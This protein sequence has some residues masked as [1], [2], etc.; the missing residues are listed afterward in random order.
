MPKFMLIAGEAS[1]DTLGAELV[2][3]LRGTE[4]GRESEYF[5]A[6]GPKM[7]E[8]GVEL[9]I[10]MTKDSVI[11]VSDAIGKGFLFWR[12]MRF[13]KGLAIERKPDVVVLVDFSFFNHKFAKVLREASDANWRPKIVKYVS[14]QVWASRPGRANE[15]PRDFDLLLSIF[16]FEKAWYKE[17]IPNFR[18][19][20]VGHPM[21]DRYA[22][23]SFARGNEKEVLL[24]PGSRT[25]ELRKHLPPMI[26]AIQQMRTSATFRCRM[27][28]PSEGLRTLA[29]TVAPLDG[30]EVG[31]G[32]LPE[33]LSQATV[34]IASSGTVTMECA[35]FRVPTVVLYKTSWT[36][37]EIGKRIV[38]VKYLAM[39]N[40][41]AD[42]E[43]FPEFIQDE[44]TGANLA[45]A[46]LELLNNEAR[47]SV[48]KTKLD[49]VIASLGEVGASGRAASHIV[50]LALGQ[51][52]PI[53]QRKP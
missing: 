9:A 34:A 39:P 47:R 50:E 4:F 13:L 38:K 1:G 44:A 11:G 53:L 28:L 42:E 17:R 48:I 40:L 6:G 15:M 49:A 18:V 23:R 30:I 22:G 14:P 7:Q 16:P 45:G 32:N 33:R 25:R 31:V 43:I 20:F 26:E 35:Y 27:V 3:A 5:G 21:V 12:R 19:E 46:A 2:K 10:D 37:Y 29:A 36:T 24:L 52:E 41:L 8:A 51:K